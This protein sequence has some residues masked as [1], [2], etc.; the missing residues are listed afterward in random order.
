MSYLWIV[1]FALGVILTVIAALNIVPLPP[2]LLAVS[3]GVVMLAVLLW[4]EIEHRSRSIPIPPEH[5]DTLRRIGGSILEDFGALR[6]I[7][8]AGDKFQSA[9][10]RQSFRA[11][12][13]PY[14]KQLDEW[15]DL[16]HAYEQSA[17]ALSSKAKATA[18]EHGLLP[19]AAMA[20]DLAATSFAQ[21]GQPSVFTFTVAPQS[22]K[23]TDI[24]YGAMGIAKLLDPAAQAV[25]GKKLE[26]QNLLNGVGAWGEVSHV[27][28][29]RRRLANRAESF[30]P[31]AAEINQS[32]DLKVARKCKVCPKR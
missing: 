9:N 22:D 10:L 30:G 29:M 20:F 26:F 28:E 19:G 1:R 16:V 32:H 27:R 2:G 5:A 8:F 23:T 21:D 24:S 6:P 4:G 15:D 17:A 13:P 12:F 25:E 3:V 31:E 14:A 11:H 18:E 7:R